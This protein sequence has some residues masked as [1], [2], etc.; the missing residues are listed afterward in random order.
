MTVYPKTLRIVFLIHAILAILV[1]IQHIFLP[2]LPG[3]L[4]GVEL[5]SAIL[6]RILGAAVFGF[7]V[8][9][10]L[11]LKEKYW[12]NVRILVIMEIV[13]STLGAFII[14]WGIF[15][16][17]LPSIEWPNAILL[18]LFAI[19]FTSLRPPKVN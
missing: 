16:E 18:L 6:Y 4:A 15:S 1:G 2:H 3:D 14:G 12:E 10:A 19:V 9:S 13:W 5:P 17:Q 11:A 8:S 7:G